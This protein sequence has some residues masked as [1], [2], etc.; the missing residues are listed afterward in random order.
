MTNIKMNVTFLNEILFWM[1]EF[2]LVLRKFRNLPASA[3][4]VD[5]TTA[6][7]EE[8]E[9]ILDMW[10]AIITPVKSGYECIFEAG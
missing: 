2:Y 10:Y 7:P 6:Q 5:T 3:A 9:F 1:N 8:D 4:G